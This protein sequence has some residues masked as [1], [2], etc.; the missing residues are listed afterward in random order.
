[1]ADLRPM[2]GEKHKLSPVEKCY[3][4]NCVTIGYSIVGDPAGQYSWIDDI[5]ESVA[6]QNM[7]TFKED[8]K[9]MTVGPLDKYFNYLEINPNST[10]YSVVWCT[11]SWNIEISKNTKVAL[12][13]KFD[14]GE[15]M[16][17]YTLWYNHSL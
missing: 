10:K 3:G 16:I 6:N 7:L 11:D 15:Q 9:K 2:F 17:M 13:C 8:V 4:Q 12:P 1:V 14:S 5:M